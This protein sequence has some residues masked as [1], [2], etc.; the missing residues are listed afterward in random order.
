MEEETGVRRKPYLSSLLGGALTT[1]MIGLLLSPSAAVAAA[2]H[3]HQNP[4]VGRAVGPVV[5]M[6]N[7]KRLP[8]IAPNVGYAHK[9]LMRHV[10]G[11]FDENQH[12]HAD[13]ADDDRQL[14]TGLR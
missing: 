7:L 3:G 13:G 10:G 8:Y 9:R 14:P 2:P 4:D 5:M 6:T 12:E 1:V 11:G